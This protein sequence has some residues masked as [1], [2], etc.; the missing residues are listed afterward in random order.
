MTNNNANQLNMLAAIAN[1]METN[2]QR[3]M[4]MQQ[5]QR[6]HRQSAALQAYMS[7]MSR[8]AAGAP[9]NRM[10]LAQAGLFRMMQQQKQQQPSMALPM[11]ASRPGTVEAPQK[12]VAPSDG[13]STTAYRVTKKAKTASSSPSISPTDVTKPL[14]PTTDIAIAPTPPVVPA[15]P[16][17]PTPAQYLKNL[18]QECKAEKQLVTLEKPQRA[19]FIKPDAKE[20]DSYN[21]AARLVREND[22]DQLRVMHKEGKNLDACNKTGESLLMIACRRG[23]VDICKFLLK[24]VQV[25]WDLRDDFGRTVL[26]DACWRPEPSVELMDVL[27]QVVSPEWLLAPDVRGHT[28]FEYARREHAGVWY[29]Y[30]KELEDELKGKIACP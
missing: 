7:V 23:H 13:D 8:A 20:T 3:A 14:T 15:A 4:Q 21:E 5:L 30:L 11:L 19:S 22:L 29:D 28:P 16:A 26:H 1:H 24:D 10:S 2:H 18:F 17:K 27:M 6:A 25:R 12:R 9:V